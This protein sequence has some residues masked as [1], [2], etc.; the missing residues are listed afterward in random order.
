MASGDSAI[1]RALQARLEQEFGA[2]EGDGEDEVA[3]DEVR[4]I[5]ITLVIWLATYRITNTVHSLG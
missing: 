4:Y 1:S 5:S 3:E 2:G